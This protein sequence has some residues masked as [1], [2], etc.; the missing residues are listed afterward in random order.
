MWPPK[1]PAVVRAIT[2]HRIK[3]SVQHLPSLIQG[4]GILHDL[5]IPFIRKSGSASVMLALA[6]ELLV[7]STGKA[8]TNTY[9]GSNN[10]VWSAD[11]NWSLGHAPLA[12]EEVMF[13]NA[14]AAILDANMT[15]SN[16][17]L[18]TGASAIVT[19][20]SGN[21]SLTLTKVNKIGSLTGYQ[22][23]YVPLILSADAQINGTVYGGGLKSYSPISGTSKALTLGCAGGSESWDTPQVSLL[24][25]NTFSGGLTI[26][27]AT[28]RFSDGGLGT[29]P[30]TLGPGSAVLFYNSI[31]VYSNTT[32]TVTVQAGTKPRSLMSQIAGSVTLPLTFVL[33]TN[34]T[35]DLNT[36]GAGAFCTLSGAISGPGGIVKNNTNTTCILSNVCTYLGA[37]QVKQ[38]TLTLNGTMSN[39][40][41]TIGHASVVARVNGSGTLAFRDGNLIDVNT[42][43]T[44]DATSL[45]SDLTALT[46]NT[47][48]LVDYSHLGTFTGPTPLANMLT[49]ASQALFT[50]TDTASQ[51]I[52]T[53]KP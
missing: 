52:A 45:K 13:T 3:I 27:Y 32:N 2:T 35:I 19:T 5:D 40:N 38:G 44:L 48:V 15:I 12:T 25:T 4:K 46:V 22:E 51:V 21:Y 23:I 11:A 37:T 33:N 42:N 53:R 14:P 1:N 49:P 29:G 34:L 43:G 36:G 28:A 20:N 26:S 16:L 31:G 30:V 39:V 47:A 41:I 7:A 50:V 24:A 17:L 9:T 6:L 8:V 18:Q 10:G